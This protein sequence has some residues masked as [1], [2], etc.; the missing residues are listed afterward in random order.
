MCGRYALTLDGKQLLEAYMAGPDD[1]TYSPS[2]NAAPT[3][4]LPILIRKGPDK[5]LG[6]VRWGLVPSWSKGPDSRYNLINARSETAHEKPAF[7]QPFRSRRCVVPASGFY[8]W[9]ASADGKVPHYIHP[10]ADP[11]FSMAG[12]YDL[13]KD[14][15]GK[16]LSGFTILTTQ[17]NQ[18]I[19]PLHDRMPALLYGKEVDQWLD[20][21]FY[22]VDALRELLR[23]APEDAAVFHEVSTN[24]NSPRN[25][26]P[27]L[28]D[29]VR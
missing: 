21:D 27:S 9:K 16:L 7:R 17:A 20:P 2:Y 12:L 26:N 3:T 13:W 8:E 5:R 1:F 29:P 4:K 28:I 11:L 24:V 15:D 19:E 6:L 18:T 14:S 25:N 10:K 22:D 23:P